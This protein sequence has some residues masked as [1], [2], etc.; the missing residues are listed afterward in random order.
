MTSDASVMT[1]RSV[2]S[3]CVA[4]AALV[5][6][7]PRADAQV[8]LDSLRAAHNCAAALRIVQHGNPDTKEDWAWSTLPG[9]GAAASGAARDAWLVQRTVTDTVQIAETFNRLWSFRDASLFEAAMG[10]A[11]DASATYQSRVFSVMMLVEQLLDGELTEY[12]YFST[13]PATGVCR[14]GDVFDRQIRVGTP[15]AADAR[16]RAHTLAQSLAASTDA[17]AAVQSAGRCL[18]QAL[19]INDHVQAT[20]PNR[21]PPGAD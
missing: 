11:A 17:P 2:F 8:D 18:D 3:S 1:L 15:L 16:Q 14:I 6:L 10:M 13:T 21:P 19:T 7:S 12:R 4:L 5:T 20:R 9:C